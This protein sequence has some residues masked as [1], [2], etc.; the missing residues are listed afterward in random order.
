MTDEEALAAFRLLSETEGIIPA[1]EPAHALAYLAKL[2]PG[3]GEDELVLVNLSGRGD[4][5][6]GTVAEALGVT[7]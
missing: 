4:K 7:L 5:D 3:L 1:L 6:M 2:L